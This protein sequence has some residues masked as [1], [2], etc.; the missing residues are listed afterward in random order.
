LKILFEMATVS[1]IDFVINRSKYGKTMIYIYSAHE[2]RPILLEI[3]S[4]LDVKRES[5]TL[6]YMLWEDI[7]EHIVYDQKQGYTLSLEL[8]ALYYLSHLK[9]KKKELSAELIQ[10]R[11]RHYKE[12]TKT[13][14]EEYSNWFETLLERP[15]ER[16]AVA[17]KANRALVK[18]GV[19]FTPKEAVKASS[20]RQLRMKIS[21]HRIYAQMM[22]KVK[23]IPVVGPDG[24][25]K[26][27]LIERLKKRSYSKIK[28]YRFKNLFRHSVFYQ[29]M[30]LFLR[31]GAAKNIAKNQYDDLYG[32]KM[33]TIAALRYPLLALSSILSKRFYLSDRFFHDLILQDVRFLER[34]AHLR[35]NWKQLL[36]KS[37]ATFW[38]I[39]LDAPTDV[40]LSRKDELNAEAINRYRE[41]VFMMYLEKPSLVYS[42]I[43]TALPIEVCSEHLLQAGKAI[44]IKTNAK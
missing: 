20:E 24:V 30:A 17:S 8:E 44:G 26:T 27:S 34:K 21:L 7:A 10:T 25:G 9:S 38:F 42:Y 3:W 19:L 37:P 36:H 6:G 39:H 28:Y 41:D 4:Y 2:T 5:E 18:L 40:I 43:N 15:Q 33:V 12:V 29:I 11:L 23:I 31:R 14:S 1:E 13:F 16:D 22:K 35:K 32:D